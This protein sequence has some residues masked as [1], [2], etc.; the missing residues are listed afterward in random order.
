MITRS[1]NTRIERTTANRTDFDKLAF[2]CKARSDNPKRPFLNVL[3]VERT[4][5][6]CRLIATDGLRLHVAECR[7]K[8]AGGDYR[9]YVTKDVINIGEPVSGVSFPNWARVIPENAKKQADIDLS[10]TGLGKD[11]KQSSKLSQVFK[12]F[13]IK[14]GKLVN[15]CFMDDLPK[16][17]W[18]VY[19]QKEGKTPLVF[20][21]KTDPEGTFAVMMPLPEAA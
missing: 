19:V 15:L 5:A 1:D 18:S 21:Q 17:E 9:P 3:H 4:R 12:A 7:L 10:D 14:T 2:V 20:K 6:G 16:T 13:I 11:V 8:I